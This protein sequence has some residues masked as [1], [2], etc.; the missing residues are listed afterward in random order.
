MPPIES[1]STSARRQEHVTAEVGDLLKQYRDALDALA[2]ARPPGLQAKLAAALRTR[3][4]IKARL[5]NEFSEGAGDIL[6]LSILD[7]KLK[8]LAPA[9]ERHIGVRGIRS[10]Q[11]VGTETESRWWWK[12]DEELN[13]TQIVW[14]TVTAVAFTGAVSL[15]T[16]IARRFFADGPDFAGVFYTLI[17]ASLALL[18]GSTLISLGSSP[19]ERFLDSKGVRRGRHPM[20][21]AGLACLALAIVFAGLR[22]LPSVAS[23]Y[24]DR[25]AAAFADGQISGAI[26]RFKTALSLNPD[27]AQAHYNLGRAYESVLS[28]DSA[29]SEYQK[30]VQ[31]QP[32]FYVA[33]NSLARLYILD[34]QDPAN[35]LDRID[36]GLA[37]IAASDAKT[38]ADQI[39]QVRLALY[40]NRGWAN[41]Q[42]GNYAQARA[43]LQEALAIEEERAS[44]HCLLAQINEKVGIKGLAEWSLC[45]GYSHDAIDV[46][47]AWLATAQDRLAQSEVRK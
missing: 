15:V 47:P 9:I 39:Q 26:Q 31:A 45:I 29:L 30:A 28:H 40:K 37:L 1:R 4:A 14:T 41:L 42:L 16:E 24:N 32:A 44:V 3:D 5:D 12:L 11:S 34:K 33:Y 43:D 35:A 17:Q 46:E 7:K 18:A 38:P 10:L 21:K 13:Q 2:G 23:W 25:G 19:V 6:E 36:R 8:G 22:A 27:F 20:I